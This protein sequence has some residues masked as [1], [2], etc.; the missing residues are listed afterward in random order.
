MKLDV[1]QV[2]ALFKEHKPANLD[3]ILDIGLSLHPIGSGVFRNTYQI[4][5]LPLIVKIPMSISWDE[6]VEHS[7]IE[8]AKINKIKKDKKYKLL[9]RY[10]PEVYYANKQGIILMPKYRMLKYNE[11]RIVSDFIGNMLFDINGDSGD[12]HSSN[13]A[14]NADGEYVIIDLGLI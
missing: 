1:D 13:V 11:G 10:L 14:C 6:N 4:N 9:R 5:K 7:L 8:I 2:I 3:E 12:M